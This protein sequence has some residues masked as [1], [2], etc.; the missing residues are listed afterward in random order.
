MTA[1][2]LAIDAYRRLRGGEPEIILENRFFEANPTNLR[3]KVALL[4]RPALRYR[5]EVGSGPVRQ[6]A[7][8]SGCFQNDLFVV[9]ANDLLR[10]HKSN[11][12]LPDTVTPIAGFVDGLTAES[13]PEICIRP[14]AVFIADG[15][16][17][18]YTNGV[19]A[20]VQIATPDDV[21]V[22]SLDIIN[23]YI[24]VVVADSQRCYWIN[25]GEFIIDPLNFFEAE[26]S[27]DWLYQV[28]TVGD[29]FWLLGAATTEVWRHTGNALAPFQRIEGRLF[30]NGVWGGTAVKIKQDVVVVG[31]DGH[32]YRVGGAPEP[33]SNPGIAEMI[34]DAM[35]KQGLV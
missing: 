11:V 23:G 33:V 31:N 10:V 2:R 34:R 4:V 21:A 9:S 19:A 25:P 20:L 35:K 24:I 27:P 6:T 15:L 14:D 18:Q 29:Q 17:L 8:N 32:V 12:G 28:R 1:V 22:V 7:Y 13:V 30:D 26:R 16:T 5:T 3:E